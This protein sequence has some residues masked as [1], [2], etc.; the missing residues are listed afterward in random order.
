MNESPV[1]FEIFLNKFF[2][3]SW[4]PGLD[5]YRDHLIGLNKVAMASGAPVEG[6]LFVHHMSTELPDL[7]VEEFKPRVRTR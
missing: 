7:P 4:E 5:V 6:S 2:D 1:E 3:A